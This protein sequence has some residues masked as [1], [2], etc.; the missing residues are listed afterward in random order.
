MTSEKSFYTGQSRS[1]TFEKQNPIF[2]WLYIL[3]FA[4]VFLCTAFFI[5]RSVGYERGY[6]DGQPVGAHENSVYLASRLNDLFNNVY[7][8]S[9]QDGKRF[10]HVSVHAYSLSDDNSVDVHVDFA[11]SDLN[12]SYHAVVLTNGDVQIDPVKKGKVDPETF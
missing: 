11:N 8:S 10:G 3:I 2:K 12:R 1:L 7:D 9:I 4:A 5:G 6:A